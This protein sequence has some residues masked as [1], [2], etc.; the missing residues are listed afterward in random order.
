MK[1]VA[2]ASLAIYAVLVIIR[3]VVLPPMGLHADYN[4]EAFKC[5]SNMYYCT[6][7]KYTISTCAV[8]FNKTTTGT[9]MRIDCDATPVL[10][11]RSNVNCDDLV[12]PD[13]HPTQ[14]ALYQPYCY[15]KRACQDD[16]CKYNCNVTMK[17]MY[18][19]TVEVRDLNFGPTWYRAN[20]SWPL[21]DGADF[22][23]NAVACDYTLAYDE[24]WK[25]IVMIRLYIQ[26]KGSYGFLV[27]KDLLLQ[28]PILSV[29]IALFFVKFWFRLPK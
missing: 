27:A 24:H 16:I 3:L 29:L 11:A 26:P 19:A 28:I 20:T 23:G 1:D 13:V 4:I 14:A 18:N 8:R 17:A 15:K 10:R 5:G 9:E 2:L 6:P 25:E 21:R 7:A 22:S 12:H